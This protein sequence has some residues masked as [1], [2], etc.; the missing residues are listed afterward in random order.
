MTTHHEYKAI[1]KLLDEHVK[2][3]AERLG[4]RPLEMWPRGGRELQLED[5]RLITTPCE[6]CTWPLPWYRLAYWRDIEIPHGASVADLTLAAAGEMIRRL[7]DEHGPGRVVFRGS[8]LVHIVNDDGQWLLRSDRIDGLCVR[9]R[10][11]HGHE[12]DGVA[13]R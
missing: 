6:R 1:A 12:A 8:G 3:E 4:L 10:T 13:N 9:L 2:A 7:H 11:I 5:G